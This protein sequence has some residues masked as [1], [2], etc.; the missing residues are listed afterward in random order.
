MPLG[1]SAPLGPP[2][3]GT[4]PFRTMGLRRAAEPLPRPP[5]PAAASGWAGLAPGAVAADERD[6]ASAEAAPAG[7]VCS[8][9]PAP[10][11]AVATV[12]TDGVRDPPS[13]V[14]CEPTTPPTGRGVAS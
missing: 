5:G 6:D 1:P 2:S 10:G 4:R 13:D 9:P 14:S 11:A 8:A 7:G 3:D 12:C